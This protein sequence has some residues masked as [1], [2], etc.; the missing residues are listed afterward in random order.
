MTIE[1]IDNG[2]Q[3]VLKRNPAFVSTDNSG[4]EG[5]FSMGDIREFL[6][7]AEVTGATDDSCIWFDFDGHAQRVKSIHFKVENGIVASE[8]PVP[9]RMTTPTVIALTSAVWLIVLA[10]MILL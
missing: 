4:G 5:R 1:R 2:G 10:L 7:E 3:I 9:G 6:F 8:T